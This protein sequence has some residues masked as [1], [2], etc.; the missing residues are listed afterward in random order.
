MPLMERGYLLAHAIELQEQQVPALLIRQ[1]LGVRHLGCRVLCVAVGLQSIIDSV[2]YLRGHGNLL[3]PEHLFRQH[4][5]GVPVVVD[6][7]LAQAYGV[8]TI[9]HLGGELSWAY[10]ELLLNVAGNAE[11]I[12]Q[13]RPRVLG[14]Q[15]ISTAGSETW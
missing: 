6:T 2:N 1:E 3:K 13:K 11:H 4:C 9:H 8:H 10:L 12:E 15:P 14:N 7:V 5:Q